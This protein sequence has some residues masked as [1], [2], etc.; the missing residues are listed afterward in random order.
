[1]KNSCLVILNEVKNLEGHSC[2][3]RSFTTFRM[4]KGEEPS[5]FC[6][7]IIHKTR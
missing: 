4:T 2:V 1:M 7:M 6:G 5:Y 3:F